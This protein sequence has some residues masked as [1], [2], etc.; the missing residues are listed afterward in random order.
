MAGNE[1]VNDRRPRRFCAD[2]LYFLQFLL[3]GIVLDVFINFLHGRQEGRCRKAGRRLCLFLFYAAFLI[4]GRIALAHDGQGLAFVFVVLF[5]VAAV[6][7]APAHLRN[8]P[9][10]GDEAF[11]GSGNVDTHLV[12]F[13][14]RVKLGDVGP[15]NEVIYV[16]LH[17]RELGEVAG[18]SRG[19]DGVVG[20]NLAVVPGT[21]LALAVGLAGP[22]A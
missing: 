2:A 21:A 20:R 3:Q 17:R 22:F 5:L 14:I 11:T 15:G 13:V 19:D 8:R 12:V 16:L 9:A 7:V 10:V 18:D 6:E 4:P 1:L